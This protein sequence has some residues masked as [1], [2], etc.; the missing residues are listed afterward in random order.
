MRVC[1][2]AK[3]SGKVTSVMAANSRRIASL[4]ASIVRGLLLY[5]RRFSRPH[6]KKSGGVILVTLA[7][8]NFSKL[9]GHGNNFQFSS[10]L[11]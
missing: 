9:I 5:T 3:T 1:K 8:I 4:R 10:C 11:L 6:K 7:A 2:L